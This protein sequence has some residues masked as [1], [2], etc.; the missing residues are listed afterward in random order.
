V[1][2]A[3]GGPRRT[4]AGAM[5]RRKWPQPPWAPPASARRNQ[6]SACPARSCVC[7]AGRCV[8]CRP[9]L[10]QFRQSPAPRSSPPAGRQEED[11]EH[12][13]A[14]R[15]F[16]ACRALAA[17]AATSW[18]PMAGANE[19][20]VGSPN[21]GHLLVYY[22]QPSVQAAPADSRLRNRIPA[23]RDQQDFSASSSE[24]TDWPRPSPAPPAGRQLI[25]EII[26][27]SET[28]GAA[29]TKLLL[30]VAEPR[31]VGRYVRV[32]RQLAS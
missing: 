2:R 5:C 30:I 6:Q 16:R 29:A 17:A 27:S 13:P 32:R 25:L 22:F 8:R 19:Y 21:D 28:V 31:V 1:N 15:D 7:R 9:D 18:L 10:I 24:R 4:L 3:A 14:A 20:A 23:R 26:S 12:W 11:N